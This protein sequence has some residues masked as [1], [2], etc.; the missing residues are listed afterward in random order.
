MP[1]ISRQIRM[2]FS[3]TR[4]FET[5]KALTVSL[6]ET[7][8]KGHLWSLTVWQTDTH[9]V[10][11][12]DCAGCK[13]CGMWRPGAGG[14]AAADLVRLGCKG[15]RTPQRPWRPKASEAAKAARTR[16]TPVQCDNI[17]ILAAPAAS[18]YASRSAGFVVNPNLKHLTPL[19]AWRNSTGSLLPDYNWTG[20]PHSL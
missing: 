15:C 6:V 14:T 13:M 16:G 1:T 3:T 12:L 4:T 5:Q 2:P 19:C 18:L 17:G 8:C 9:G 11:K 20:P 7:T 10:G